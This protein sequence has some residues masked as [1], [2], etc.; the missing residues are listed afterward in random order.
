[1]IIALRADNLQNM[2]VIGARCTRD[3][4]RCVD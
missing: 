1:M 3:A 2:D 4:S